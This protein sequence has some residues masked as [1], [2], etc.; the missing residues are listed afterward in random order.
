MLVPLGAIFVD[1]VISGEGADFN[2]VLFALGTGMAMGVIAASVFQ[3]R[4]SRARAFPFALVVAG[5]SLLVAASA[6]VLSIIV[7]AIAVV[8]FAAGPIYVLGFTLLHENVDDEL[9]GRIFASLLVLVRFCV[10][11]ALAIA[12]VMSELLDGLSDALWGRSI[13]IGEVTVFVP[14]VRLTMWLSAV[15]IM[16]AGVL[17]MISLRAGS[18]AFVRDAAVDAH[19]EQSVADVDRAES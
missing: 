2:L 12:P 8:G 9:R 17:A 14:G 18:G 6:S 1:E 15:I 13:G 7:P 5:G 11:L 3:G 4:I 10:L 16:T 19:A